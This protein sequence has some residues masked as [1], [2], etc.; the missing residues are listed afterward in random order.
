MAADDP[1]AGLARYQ[2]AVR[3]RPDYFKARLQMG[4]ALE[5]LGPRPGALAIYES[6]VREVPGS[7]EA[8]ERMSLL[9]MVSNQWDRARDMLE[10][11]AAMPPSAD[12][13]GT[14]LLFAKQMLCDWSDRQTDLESLG[15][16]VDSR[17]ARGEPG[18]VTPFYAIVFAWPA[19]R[20]LAI[21]RAESQLLSV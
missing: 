2:E 16:A 5:S 20:Q 7:R 19:A 8:R 1:A 3:L 11:L 9:L 15:R 14:N 17:L 6:L 4:V 18:G 13:P 21:A 12:P 10:H